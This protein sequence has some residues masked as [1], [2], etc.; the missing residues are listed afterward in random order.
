MQPWFAVSTGLIFAVAFKRLN[1]PLITCSSGYR[2]SYCYDFP[3]L[4]CSQY[5]RKREL[6]LANINPFMTRIG[7][8]SNLDQTT[9]SDLIISERI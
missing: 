5:Q 7:V 1:H 6:R 2:Q 3:F 8:C 4:L 9:C